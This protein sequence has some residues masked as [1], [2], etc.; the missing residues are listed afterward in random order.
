MR[1]IGLAA[2]LVLTACS[3][4]HTPAPDPSVGPGNTVRVAGTNTT[5]VSN[6]AMRV[7]PSYDVAV[8][9]IYAGVEPIWAALPFIYTALSIPLTTA[10]NQRLRF[11]NEGMKIRRRLGETPLVKLLDC[12]RTQIDQNAESYDIHMSVMTV[13]RRHDAQI[14]IVST[15]VEASGKPPQFGGSETRCRTKGELEKAIVLALRA[16]VEK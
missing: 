12:G 13:L 15:S 3:S 16:R 8:D 1:A 4:S 14:T 11:G 9:T 7:T 10:D 5:G 2:L 6:N